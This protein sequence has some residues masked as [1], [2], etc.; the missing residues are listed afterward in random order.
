[1]I[2]GKEEER[3]STEL[4]GVAKAGLLPGQGTGLLSVK[5]VVR[6]ADTHLSWQSSNVRVQWVG[7]EL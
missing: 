3:R 1:M 6:E 7:L 5:K 4:D 2:H